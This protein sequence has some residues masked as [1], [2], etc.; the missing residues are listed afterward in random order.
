MHKSSPEGL[1]FFLG[2]G[3][4]IVAGG[5]PCADSFSPQPARAI[6]PK[7]TMIIFI[8]SLH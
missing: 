8:I 6:T 1:Y 3:A 4:G 2:W 5:M 7:N